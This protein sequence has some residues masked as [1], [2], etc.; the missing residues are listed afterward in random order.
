MIK[1]GARGVRIHWES[2]HDLV[3][4]ALESKRF[5]KKLYNVHRAAAPKFNFYHFSIQSLFGW[6]AITA[7]CAEIRHL[8]TLKDKCLASRMH[9]FL[10]K[11]NMVLRGSLCV[12]STNFTRNEEMNHSPQLLAELRQSTVFDKLQMLGFKSTRREE[13]RSDHRLPLLRSP[14]PGKQVWNAPFEIV[15]WS[16]AE[17][18]SQTTTGAQKGSH[19]ICMRG[20]VGLPMTMNN[21]T[22]VSAA[23]SI[24][25]AL[26][27]LAG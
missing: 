22:A 10:R 26:R 7:C 17:E 19:Y 6:E 2:V 13:H 14:L 11:A 5:F 8:L 24:S 9:S 18:Q 16:Y 21:K 1:T 23:V 27:R 12:Y 25:S 3:A 15:F 20:Q 4:K